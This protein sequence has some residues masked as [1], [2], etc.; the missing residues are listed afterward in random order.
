MS[1]LHIIW[2]GVQPSSIE[3]YFPKT[4]S[5]WRLVAQPDLAICR[6]LNRI[7][8]T[9]SRCP[10]M[11][12]AHMVYNA[13]PQFLQHEG[14]VY[15][16]DDT[17]I[18][19]YPKKFCILVALSTHK[20]KMVSNSWSPWPK[21]WHFFFLAAYMYIMFVKLVRIHSTVVL[22]ERSSWSTCKIYATRPTN[23]VCFDIVG[24]SLQYNKAV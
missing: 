2:Q 3:N 14:Y 16:Q 23:G 12:I 17:S 21:S 1:V 9:L 13:D 22:P 11:I 8:H 15:K 10:L 20:P 19:T 24:F 5:S 7:V 6:L 18:V 4:L